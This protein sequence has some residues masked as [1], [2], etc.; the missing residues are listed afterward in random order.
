MRSTIL[1]SALCLSTPAAL[2][3]GLLIP[4]STGDVLMLFS[5]VDGSL[6]NAN[7]VDM[8]AL[9]AAP[10][11]PIEALEVGGELW[12]SD[13]VADVILRFSADGTTYL[14]EYGM[15]RDNIR[16]F[17]AI[18]GG[19]WLANAGTGGAGYGQVIK[20]YDASGMLLGTSPVGSPF[21]VVGFGADM[22]VANIVDENIELFDTAG[23]FLS[24]FHD[25]DGLT[26]IDFP[27]QLKI[28]ASNGNVLAAGFADPSGLYEYDSSGTE[29]AYIDTGLTGLR[30][31]HELQNGN[32]LFTN[33]AG[34]HVWDVTTATVTTVMAGVSARF[35]SEWSGGSMPIGNSYCG[36]AIANSTGFPAE[37]TAAGSTNVNANNVTLNVIQVPAGQFGY[38]LVSRDQGFFQPPGSSG[39][40][41]V[42]NDIGR[43]NSVPEIITGPSGSLS[44]DLTMLPTNT[45]GSQMTMAGETLNFQ[46]WYRDTGSTSNFSDGVSISF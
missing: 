37:I 2:C 15:G 38:F 36:P 23:N 17:A 11:T 45:P 8:T 32:L 13:Q 5:P 16:G 26:G 34:V 21:D 9:G 3:Q 30:G 19:I 7:Q 14:G 43:Y 28:K 35:I 29:V 33:G 18:G 25:S 12:V 31:V 41:C 39:F 44:V 1:I 6:I 24:T 22:L 42:A 10:S 4:D 46:C 20:N 40:I 27:E